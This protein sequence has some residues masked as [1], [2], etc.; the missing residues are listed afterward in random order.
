MNRQ[1]L[2]DV[3]RFAALLARF[4]PAAPVHHVAPAVVAL[5]EASVA[6]HRAAEHECNG[7]PS[8]D[9]ANRQGWKPEAISKLHDA[10]AAHIERLRKRARKLIAEAAEALKIP[11]DSFEISGDP[12][13][14]CLRWKHA[15]QE[16]A[17][18]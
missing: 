14:P 10:N 13:G 12:R 15:D 9:Y 16:I 5:H 8:L 2:R 4:N 18:P 11:L 3:A 1:D 17:V 6:C 7:H